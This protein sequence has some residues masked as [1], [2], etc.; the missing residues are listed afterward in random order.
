MKSPKP[1]NIN[2]EFHPFKYPFSTKT[3][4]NRDFKT[5]EGGFLDILLTRRSSQ[6]LGHISLEDIAELLYYSNK[7]QSIN[8]DDSG[9]L[10]SKRTVP[11]AG[12][13]HPIDLLVSL[14]S[15]SKRFL[16][17]YNPIDHSL[18]ELSIPRE[19][20]QSFFAEVNENIPVGDCCLIWFSIQ[21]KKTQ[22]KYEYA[23]SLYWRDAGSLLYCI[24]IISN[25]LGFK[26]CPLGGLAVKSFDNL[27]QTNDLISGGGI[28]VG[29]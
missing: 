28:L 17:Y 4:L 11:S 29:R 21:T 5:R 2:D 12:G 15:E 8:I 19:L 24:Q 10:I 26:S 7:V 23:E 22:S 18:S 6:N 1:K 16:H 14:P 27:F 25:Y 20:Q 3:K 9:F 13:R